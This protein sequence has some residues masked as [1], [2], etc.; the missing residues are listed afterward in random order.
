MIRRLVPAVLLVAIAAV[1]LLVAW[2]QLFH[3][4]RLPLVAQA[5]SLRPLAIAGAV[6][7]AVVFGLVA[8]LARGVR[9]FA[10][11]VVLLLVVFSGFN[12][13]VLSSRGFG[14]VTFEA[15]TDSDVTV[16]SWNTLG[17]A[18]GAKTVA[19]LA[20]AEGADIITLPETTLDMGTAIAERMARAG[21]PMYV[22]TEAFDQISKARSTTL[23]VS[24]SLGEYRKVTEL[25]STGQLPSVIAE[26]VN[27]D[28]PRIVSVHPVAPIPSELDGWS[29]DLDWLATAC[30][31]D[32]VIMAGDFNSTIDHFTHIEHADGATIGNCSDAAELSG[33]AA[34][35]TWPTF[36]PP[37]LGTPI[38]HVLVTDNWRVSGLRVVE[39]LDDAGSDHRPVVAQ[40]SP[41]G[42]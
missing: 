40:L 31:A 10:A 11:S 12:L 41:T 2:P 7:A 42:S 27:G 35:G 23:L 15:A 4:E 37:V 18:P 30:N 14:D 21:Q 13:A 29:V 32:N 6:A 19:E 26:P 34:V 9:R 5:V 22:F 20:L 28:G 33:N 17:D 24:D 3:A 1:L 36:L 16:L 8:L 39:S 25:G 38:D